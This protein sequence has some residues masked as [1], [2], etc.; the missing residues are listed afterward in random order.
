MRPE[1]GIRLY[2]LYPP[3]GPVIGPLVMAGVLVDE[4]DLAKLKSIGVKDSKLLTRKKRDELFEK[5]KRIAKA[6][7]IIIA[8][9]KEIDNALES[10]HLNLN[11]LEAHKTAEIINKLKPAKVTVDS[12]SNNCSAYAVYLKKLI[13]DRKIELECIHK[14]DVKHVYVGAASILAKVVRDK[15]MDKINKK[16]GNCGPGYMSN[17]VTQKFLAENWEKH[18]EIF[19][20]TWVPYKNHKMMKH[21]KKLE[22]F[23]K[24]VEV[25]IPELKELGYKQVNVTSPYEAGRFKGK[26]TIVLYHTKKALIQGKEDRKEEIKRILRKN[27]YKL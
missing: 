4:K 3:A 8:E 6:F 24:F 14:A 11:W 21:Q 13:K 1:A 12:P 23:H 19:R 20:K 7:E 25:D 18:P 17:E 27:G 22:D 5:I 10:D 15:E 16:Y 26:A 9:P 2:P